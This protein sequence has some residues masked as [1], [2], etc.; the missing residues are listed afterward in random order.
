MFRAQSV[1]VDHLKSA[2]PE[3]IKRAYEGDSGIRTAINREATAGDVVWQRWL[4]RTYRVKFYTK[5]EVD[6]YNKSRV[7]KL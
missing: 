3:D 7:T 5:E 6:A 4:T 1:N 2:T